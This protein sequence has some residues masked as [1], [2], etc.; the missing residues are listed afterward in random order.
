[1]PG[2]TDA[3]DIRNYFLTK[4]SL[5]PSG[6]SAQLNLQAGASFAKQYHIGSHFATFEFGGK[7][8]NAH[9]FDDTQTL[10][11]KFKNVPAAQFLG[12][13]TD[14]DY[15]DGTY[16]FT[17]TPDYTM[18]RNFAEASGAIAASGING[19]NY[20]LIE[21][22]TAGYLMNTIDLTPRFRLVAGVRFE[23]THVATLS[24]N[25]GQDAAGNPALPA[26]NVPGGSD[27]LDVLPSVSLRFAVAK[28]SALR[29]VFSCGLSRPDPQDISQSATTLD[30][31]QSPNLIQLGNPNLKAEH[32]N[33]YDLLFE[34]YLKPVGI[35]QAGVFFKQ[36][37][38]PIVNGLFP[39]SPSLFASQGPTSPYVLVQ[40]VQ[41][42]GSARLFG[43]EVGY[44]QRLSFLPGVMKGVGISANYSYTNSRTEGLEGLFR[45]DHPALLRQAPNTWNISPTFDTKKF[46]MRVGMTYNDAMIFAYQF[47]NLEAGPTSIIP[48]TPAE[49]AQSAAGGVKGPGGD[50]YL[51]AHYQIDAQGSYKVT[52]SLSVYAYGLNLNN[53]VFGFYNGS[54]QYVVQREY[55]KPTFAGGVRYTFTRE[56]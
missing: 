43:F 3:T 17:N 36:L 12:S 13:F 28:D 9:K 52:R 47:Q 14:P 5:P 31:S 2:A 26:V 25:N 34:Q 32:S 24:F 15:Y 4:F 11:A 44:S 21:R 42:I 38:D 48:K 1:V 50:N 46:S 55:Y 40:Q 39:E 20:N 54:P 18:V 29:A 53:E 35:L 41:N 27:Y 30:T 16:H 49:L 6:L 23:A 56:R 37:R 33:N 51:Y 22:V 10:I 8:R 19:N 7:I 45:D